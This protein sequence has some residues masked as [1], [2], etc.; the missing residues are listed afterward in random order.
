MAILLLLAFLLIPIIEIAAFIEV[1]SVIGLW[2]TL[3]LTV[4]TA[5]A[6]AMLVRHQ[7]FHVLRELKDEADRGELPVEPVVHA[8]FLLIAGLCLLTPGF[9]TDAAGFVLL[10]PPARLAIARWL[11]RHMRR[12]ADVTIV[13]AAM[14]ERPGQPERAGPVID[15]EAEEIAANGPEPQRRP[16]LPSPWMKGGSPTR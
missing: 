8:A 10:V 11:W 5:I 13:G 9:V 6:G 12:H 16:A 4:A 7:G 3:A 1:G 15:L 2:P 14:H